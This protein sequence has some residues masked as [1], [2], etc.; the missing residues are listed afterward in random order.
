M[1]ITKSGWSIKW[2]TAKPERAS[3]GKPAGQF[4][5]DPPF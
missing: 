4:N 5:D 1:N 2:A 3:N